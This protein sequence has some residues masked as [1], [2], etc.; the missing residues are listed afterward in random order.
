MKEVVYEIDGY[1]AS[2][3]SGE[4]IALI[5]GV[6]VATLVLIFVGVLGGQSY[7]LTETDINN[8]NNTTIQGYIKDAISSSFKALKTTGNFLPLIV[9]AVIIFLVIGLVIGGLGGFAGYGGRG[10][11]TPL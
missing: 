6:G 7:S 3:S 10:G 2:M 9:L 5:V 4:I 1:A 8:I 11:G